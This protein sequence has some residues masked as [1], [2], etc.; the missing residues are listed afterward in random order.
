MSARR[1]L[2][3]LDT[4]M[5]TRIGVIA[6][7]SQEL[8]ASILKSDKYWLR[9]IDDWYKLTEGAITNEQFKSL[10]DS[11][12]GENTLK[13]LMGSVKTGINAFILRVLTDSDTIERDGVIKQNEAL[14]ITVNLYPYEIDYSLEEAYRKVL[15]YE[16]GQ[17][18]EINFISM[19]LDELTP[20]HIF[21]GYGLF[22]TYDFQEWFKLHHKAV[23][24]QRRPDVYIVAPKIFEKMPENYNKEQKQKEFNRFKLDLLYFVNIEFIDVGYFSIITK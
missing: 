2:V 23:I 7:Y 10:W 8:A 16:Y 4:L 22:I 9:E 11:R 17:E 5:D 12:G 3:S 14:E 24:K 20:D 21:N 6:N 13:T 15:K 19:S 18:I 1:I